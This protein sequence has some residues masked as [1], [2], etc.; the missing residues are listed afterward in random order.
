MSSASLQNS[1]EF[2]PEQGTLRRAGG[3]R[4]AAFSIEFVQA[5]HVGLLEEFG[6]NAQDV[7]YRTGY[8][9]GLQEMITRDR[10]LRGESRRGAKPGQLDAK[11]VLDAWWAPLAEGGWGICTFDVAALPRGFVLAEMRGSAIAAAFPGSDQPVCHLYAGM[12]A[13]GV[14]FYARAERHGTE[15]QCS[16]V[17]GDTCRFVVAAGSAVDSAESWRQKGM[18]AAEIVRRLGQAK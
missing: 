18:S 15:L 8:E 1:F 3:A 11:F 10:Q 4:A 9:W 7:L 12:L 16:A 2:D 13:A 17:S 14:S 6:E 5:L